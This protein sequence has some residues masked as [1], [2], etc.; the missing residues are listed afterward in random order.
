MR[1]VRGDNERI[2]ALLLH[3]RKHG[4]HHR[5]GLQQEYVR[6]VDRATRIQDRYDVKMVFEG[7]G[8]GT[9]HT[10]HPL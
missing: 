6:I 9:L 2:D 4:C 1:V 10:R 3:P 5:R 7:K 8:C